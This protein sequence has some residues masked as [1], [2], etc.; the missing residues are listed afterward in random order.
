MIIKIVLLGLCVCILNLLLRQSQSVFAVAVNILFA[1]TAVILLSDYISDCIDKLKEIMTFSR[2]S[3]TMLVCLY[4]GALICVLTK[5][6]SDI[7]KE[8]GNAVV[9]DIIDIAGRIAMLIVA[10][11]FIESIIKTAA[12]F[13]L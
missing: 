9:S 5:I 4:K 2:E 11:P 8:S 6:S 12:A 10:F 7:S 1:V 3:G 13:I